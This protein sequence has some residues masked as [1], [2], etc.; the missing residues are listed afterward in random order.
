MVENK[1]V[2]L[3]RDKVFF[4]P[5]TLPLI[6]GVFSLLS[7]TFS[8]L[9]IFIAFINLGLFLALKM[10]E[11][12]TGSLW[13]TGTSLQYR[14]GNQIQDSIN[15]TEIDSIQIKEL[16]TSIKK[17]LFEISISTSERPFFMTVTKNKGIFETLKKDL[18]K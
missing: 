18:V 2:C 15:L 3:H 10:T 8:P 5:S 7:V 9:F 16:H 13:T 6:F 4:I 14:L 1:A 11:K 12:H 17:E